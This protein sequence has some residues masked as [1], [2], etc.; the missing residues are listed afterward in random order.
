MVLRFRGSTPTDVM[1]CGEDWLPGWALAGWLVP[2]ED[3]FPEIAKY[4][5]KVANYAVRDMTYNGKL[6]GLP[7]YADLITFQYNAKIL[8]DHGIAMPQ[9]LGSGAGRLP[10]AQAGGHGEAVR[11][12]VRPGP[13]RTSTK[14]SSRRYTAAAGGCST[15]TSSRCSTTRTPR[16]SSICSGCRT[17]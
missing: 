4:K 5:D 10:Q 17:P 6:Y 7:Y 9:D 15:T 2:I 11:L 12:R 13:C 16:R 3:Q 1:Y 14:P 8:A